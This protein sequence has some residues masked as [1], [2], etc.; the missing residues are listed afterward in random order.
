MTNV[1]T[2]YQILFAQSP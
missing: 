1:I 2:F